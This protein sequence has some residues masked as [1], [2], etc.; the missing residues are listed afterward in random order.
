MYFNANLEYIGIHDSNE[1][2]W[3]EI[4]KEG[5]DEGY[6]MMDKVYKIVV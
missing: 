2:H 5:S 6:K 4:I 1:L 3:W